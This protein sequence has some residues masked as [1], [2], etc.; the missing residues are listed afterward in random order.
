M[1]SCK[2]PADDTAG[3][4]VKDAQEEL[5]G[6]GTKFVFLPTSTVGFTGSKVTGSHDGGFKDFSGHF[7]VGDNETPTGGEFT[8]QMA[9]VWSDDEKLTDHLKSNDFFDVEN[10]ATS[11]FK[12]TDATK[13]DDGS[14]EV[15]GNLTM[16]GTEKNI[17]FPATASRDGGEV[18]LNA[19]FNINRR[20]FGIVYDGMADDLIRD[21]VVL[22]F[23]FKAQ[24]ET[25]E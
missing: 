7:F 8:I 17:T 13:K 12:L 6:S 3:A 22:R 1:I 21:Q 15:S 25:P 14:F 24:A 9:S 19:E 23:D 18:S 11:V 2:N 20:D 4:Q 10:H 5:Q 16:R